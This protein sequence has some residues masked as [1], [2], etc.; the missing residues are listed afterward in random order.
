MKLLKLEGS[1]RF[2]IQSDIYWILQVRNKFNNKN[3]FKF[4]KLEKKK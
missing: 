1:Q 2:V 3:H 4:M